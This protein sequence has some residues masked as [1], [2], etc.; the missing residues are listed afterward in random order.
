MTCVIDRRINSARLVRAIHGRVLNMTQP[1][2]KSLEEME[3]NR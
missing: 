1:G 3:G 2:A